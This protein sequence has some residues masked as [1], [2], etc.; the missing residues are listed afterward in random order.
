MKK[1][2]II[3][4][5][6][7]LSSACGLF[8]SVNPDSYHVNVGNSVA[9]ID[10]EQGYEKLSLYVRLEISQNYEYDSARFVWLIPLPTRPEIDDPDYQLF[11]GLSAISAP[12]YKETD[13]YGCAPYSYEEKALYSRDYYEVLQYESISPDSADTLYAEDIDTIINWLSNLG[14]TATSEQRKS[15]QY[16]IDKGWNYFYIA[17]F[18]DIDYIWAAK[19]GIKFRFTSTEEVIP[20]HITHTNRFFYRSQDTFSVY[21]YDIA[22][23]KKAYVHGKLMYANSLTQNEVNSIERDFPALGSALES[24]KY[25]TKLNISYENPEKTIV[26]DIVLDDAPDN[27]EYRELVGRDEY[28]YYGVSPFFVLV[29]LLLL[30]C[31]V[32][33]TKH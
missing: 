24:G 30:W 26:D 20:M 19:A 33:A 27:K 5:F 10:Q 13:Y 11:E 6:V 31:K 21:T 32:K 28:W 9:L 18:K 4:C 8:L 7:S 25:I 16:Y 23:C 17:L 15:I 3:L 1:Y 14:F 12:V 22:N 2:F 29:A